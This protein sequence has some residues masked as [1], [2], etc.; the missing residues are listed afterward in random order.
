[1]STKSVKRTNKAKQVAPVV[2]EGR[3]TLVCGNRAL[4]NRTGKYGTKMDDTSVVNWWE[5]FGEETWSYGVEDGRTVLVIEYI[6]AQGAL[7]KME[8]VSFRDCVTRAAGQMLHAINK[9]KRMEK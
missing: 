4:A 6:G 1:M 7:R 5:E 3:V 9:S 8:G 2:G